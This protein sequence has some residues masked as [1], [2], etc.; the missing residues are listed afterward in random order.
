MYYLEI[1]LLTRVACR[2][3]DNLPLVVPIRSLLDDHDAPTSYQLGVH[4]GIKGQY[5]GVS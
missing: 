5:A 3:L 2:I 1:F 4:V